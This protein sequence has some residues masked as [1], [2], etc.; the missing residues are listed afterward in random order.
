MNQSRFIKMLVWNVRCINSQSKWD[1]IRDKIGES[2]LQETKRNSF[3]AYYLTNFCPRHLSRFEFFPSNDASG[4]LITIWIR[5]I[6]W[7]SNSSKCLLCD[8]QALLCFYWNNFLFNYYGPSASSEKV[9]FINWL[10]NFDYSDLDD[11]ILAGDFNLIRSPD[12]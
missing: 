2:F 4:G 8:S 1:A 5:L 10:Y 11:W 7:N 9:A 3:D 12:N 6:L